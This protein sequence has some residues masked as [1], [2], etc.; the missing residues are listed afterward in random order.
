MNHTISYGE[1][2]INFLLIKSDR[3]TV[4]ISVFPDKN[5][6]VRVPQTAREEEIFL[7]VTKRLSWIVGK[8]DFYDTL[9]ARPM[10]R[11]YVSGETYLF[12]G[13]QYRLKL[14]KADTE[15]VVLKKQYIYL[16]LPLPENKNEVK[17]LLDS[18]FQKQAKKIFMEY[19]AECYSLIKKYDVKIPEL[20]VVDMKRRWGS[21]SRA[22]KILLNIKLIQHSSLCI[23]YVI[24][25][26]LCHLKYFNHGREYYS[27]LSRLMPDW[28]EIKRKLNHS[29]L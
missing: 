27:L 13:K 9:P 14:I 2:E 10:H 5:V 28:K 4:E 21:C 25:H 8:L 3:K 11:K 16:Y 7:K 23:K 26:E 15:D 29:E 18:W 12:L 17:A 20:Y 22:G 1:R 6:I 24:M 19:L